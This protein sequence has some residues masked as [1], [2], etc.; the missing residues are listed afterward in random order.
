MRD[1][2]APASHVLVVH[3]LAEVREE[4]R[5]VLRE[6]GCRVT[7]AADAQ[8][9]WKWLKGVAAMGCAPDV[10]IIDLDAPDGRCPTL[11]GMMAADPWLVELP[12][13]VT[14]AGTPGRLPSS[15]FAVLQHAVAGDVVDAVRSAPRRTGHD[16]LVSATW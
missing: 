2:N 16:E 15:V 9:A 10:V 7:C 13:A 6:A 1:S 3:D 12:V 4:R 5:A 11:V 14:T 8:T